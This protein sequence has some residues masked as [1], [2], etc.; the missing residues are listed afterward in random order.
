MGGNRR[1]DYEESHRGNLGTSAGVVNLGLAV[2]EKLAGLLLM[3]DR[4]STSCLVVV[5][6]KLQD[7]FHAKGQEGSARSDVS[8]KL[9][10]ALEKLASLV[11]FHYPGILARAYIIDPCGEYLASLD[12]PESLLERTVLLS[13]PQDLAGYL[14][15]GVPPEYGGTGKVIH[16]V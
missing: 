12:V 4:Y 14:S 3:D 10:A 2:M 5:H 1:Q 6:F 16:G 15:P 11:R 8:M 9:C 13:N 7:T